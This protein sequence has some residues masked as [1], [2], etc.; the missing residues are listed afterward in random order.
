M[1]TPVPASPAYARLAEGARAAFTG[2]RDVSALSS[3]D[4]ELGRLFAYAYR[5]Q[6]IGAFHATREA[7]ESLAGTPLVEQARARLRDL[8][9]L[10]MR[11][12]PSDFRAVAPVFASYDIWCDEVLEALAAPG[13][14]PAIGS[15][16][17]HFASVI[18]R[19]RRSEGI[20]PAR[21][22]KLPPQASYQVPGI[23]VVIVPLAYGDHISWNTAYLTAKSAGATTHRHARQAEIH[24]GYGELRGRTLLDGHAA[25]VQQGYAMP[26]PALRDHGFDNLSGHAHFVPFIFGSIELDGWGV[27]FDVEPRPADTAAWPRV[28]LESEAMN[29]SIELDPA[30]ARVR[31][32]PAGSR[33]VLVPAAR[34]ARPATGG[35]EL[36]AYRVGSRPITVS[37][38][39]FRIL[40]VYEGDVRLAFATAS[41]D[42][43][44]HEH[45]GVPANMPAALVRTGPSDAVVLEASLHPS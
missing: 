21:D 36:A 29:G 34:T 19:I 18:E 42:L 38:Q 22:D 33:H 3:S 26:I 43:G 8:Q 1:T 32:R 31:R 5:N 24:L 41:A 15:I 23:E 35:L 10:A 7:L 17:T 37:A 25:L 30:L 39:Q 20:V 6:T 2:R 28:P 27:F 11:E 45:V 13:T 40:S 16:R 9:G 14:P 12:V 4:I 44:P